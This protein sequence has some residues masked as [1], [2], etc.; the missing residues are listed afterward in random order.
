MVRGAI[1]AFII[2]RQFKPAD[3]YALAG[4]VL[5]F[6]D[7]IHGMQQRIDASPLVTLGYFFLADICLIVVWS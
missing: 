6:L 1:A 5:S 7:F 2:D 3:I 4:D